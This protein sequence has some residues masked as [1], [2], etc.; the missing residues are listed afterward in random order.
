L[1]KPEKNFYKVISMTT[2]NIIGD[3]LAV[4]GLHYLFPE[5]RVTTILAFVSL[6]SVIFAIVGLLIGYKF[7]RKE[8]DISFRKVFVNGMDL[9]QEQ[10]IKLKER[11]LKSNK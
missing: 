1:N 4:F 10:Y 8:V 2:T 5:W 6:A 7:L 9:Y 11:Y 3:I